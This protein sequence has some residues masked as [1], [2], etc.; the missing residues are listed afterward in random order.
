MPHSSQPH[1]DEWAAPTF[2]IET[3]GDRPGGALPA[4]APLLTTLR[5]VDRMEQAV[6]A[7]RLRIAPGGWLVTLSAEPAS[8]GSLSF[9]V[10]GTENSRLTLR[11]P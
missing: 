9:P 4:D 5:A 2:T 6:A 1:R 10:P 7:A 3:I 11:Q 8:E